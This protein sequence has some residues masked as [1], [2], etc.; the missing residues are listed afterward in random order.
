MDIYE[1]IKQAM[2]D[3]KS[4][5]DLAA[6]CYDY[7]QLQIDNQ[8][9]FI[10]EYVEFSDNPKQ[11]N[12]NQNDLLKFS[13][14]MKE[15]LLSEG[16]WNDRVANMILVKT[17]SVK[18]RLKPFGEDIYNTATIAYFLLM[19]ID[20]YAESQFENAQNAPLN[21][22]YQGNSFIYRCQKESI[23][24]PAAKQNHFRET[25]QAVEIRNSFSCLK[26]LGKS[27]LKQGMQP[28]KMVTLSIDKDDFA[29]NSLADNQLLKIVTIPWGSEQTCRFPKIQGNAFR[30]EYSDSYKRGCIKKALTLLEA[31]VRHKANIIVFPEYVCCPEVQEAIG[32]YLRD[33]RQ[34]NPDKIKDLLMVIAGSG[35]TEDDNNVA[36]VYSYSGKLLGMHYKYAS[37]DKMMKDTQ[38]DNSGERWI[39][40]LRNPGRESI[41]VQIPKIGSVMTAICRDISNWDY[42]EKIARIF[43]TDFLMVPAWSPSLHHAFQSQ[44]ESMTAA[45]TRTCS[46]VCNCCAAQSDDD[47][48]KGLVVTPYKSSSRVVGKTRMIRLNK[49]SAER[50]RHCRGCIFCLTLSFHP[51]DVVKGRMV[52]S[53]RNFKA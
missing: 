52:R 45:N 18:N 48:E 41:I 25:I 26:I 9:R 28:P 2:K 27:E 10:S 11:N 17:L 15:L 30:I 14:D 13:N 24:S 8:I 32:K 3:L 20:L 37:F 36:S 7:L 47:F 53:I 23:L 46:V 40:G 39:E 34:E 35:W 38:A 12:P 50:C 16:Y 4:V 1:T 42:S 21:Q 29:R 44:L 19:G 5:Y 51:Q 6:V 49:L 43:Q 31:A 22:G 33:T